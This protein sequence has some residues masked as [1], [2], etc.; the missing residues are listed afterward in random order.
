MKNKKNMILIIAII[1]IIVLG[2]TIKISLDFYQENKVKKEVEAII[3][4]LENDPENETAI[5]EILNREVVKNGKYN[6]LE[7]SIKSYYKE[8]YLNYSNLLFI[9]SED[10]FSYYLSTSTLKENRPSFINLKNNLDNTSNQLSEI[11]N[12][13]DN[14]IKDNSLKLPY[15]TEHNLNSYYK[16]LYLSLIDDYLPDTFNKIKTQKEN[17]QKKL[18]IYQEAINYL[19]THNNEWE[20]K[21]NNVTFKDIIKNDEY[22]NIINKLEEFT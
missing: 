1:V 7:T 6:K 5:N 17:A 4:I 8:F 16:K 15:I 13:I 12:T 10:N 3:N 20:L 2:I 22:Q 9:T 21:N 18:E 11:Y 19:S 14:L